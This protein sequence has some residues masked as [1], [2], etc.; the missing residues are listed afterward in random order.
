[1]EAVVD[2]NV[3]I[4]GEKFPG[5]DQFYV[6][7]EVM[8]ELESQRA[9][10]DFDL[11]EVEVRQPSEEAV[12]RVEE[13]SEEINAHTSETDEKLLG[14]ALELD[15]V[16]VTDDKGLQNLASH[17]DVS[18]ESYL[19]D[20]IEGKRSWKRLCGNCSSKFE[21]E[22]CS[23]CGSTRVQRKPDRRS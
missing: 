14:L 4:R 18:F 22:K 20:E 6:A 23:R 5:F 1:M 7:Q 2:A 12:R 3:F 11:R 8:E 9:R 16:L 13:K 21:G 10:T 19:G 15:A 17:L